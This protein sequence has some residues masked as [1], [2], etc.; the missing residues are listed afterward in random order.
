MGTG[1]TT[2]TSACAAM[3]CSRV[4]TNTPSAGSCWFGYTVVRLRILAFMQLAAPKHGQCECQMA[5]GHREVSSPGIQI[6]ALPYISAPFHS[7]GYPSATPSPSH[8]P[9][10]CRRNW[11]KYQ[12]SGAFCQEAF[13]DARLH[14]QAALISG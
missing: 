10:S 14:L 6:H 2:L 1:T 11:K 8:P 5:K 12:L 3:C 7:M 9:V 13:G 4:R